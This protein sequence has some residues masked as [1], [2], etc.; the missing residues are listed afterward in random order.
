MPVSKILH[1]LI[2]YVINFIIF[3]SGYSGEHCECNLKAHG[4]GNAKTNSQLDR[5]C[6]I[7]NNE[8]D[9]ETC[10]GNGKCLCGKC[11]CD[12]KHVGK[13]CQC[14]K[15]KC[16]KGP[17]GQICSGNGDCSFCSNGLVPECSCKSGWNGKNCACENHENSCTDYH[18]NQVCNCQYCQIDCVG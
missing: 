7:N 2:N 11:T 3:R 1:I 6:H 14:L 10:S 16:P 4:E 13:H 5:F 17:D 8:A 9:G 12:D 15:S 18:S